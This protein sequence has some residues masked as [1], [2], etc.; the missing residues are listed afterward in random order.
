MRFSFPQRLRPLFLL[1]LLL[2]LSAAHPL[3]AQTPAW[4]DATSPGAGA[5]KSTAVDAAGNT[6]VTGSFIGTATFGAITLT[7]AGSFDIFVAKRNPAGVWQWATRAGGSS[8]DSGNGVAVDGSGNVVVTGEFNSPT[9][10]FGATT[11]TNATGSGDLFVAK[12]TPTGAWQWATGAGSSDDASGSSVA[13]DGSDNVVVTGFFRSPTITFGTITLTNAAAL[14]YDIF[15]AKLTP[16][17]AWQWATS[18]GSSDDDSG[19][20]VAV[21]GSGNVVVTGFFA[22][23]TL[24]FGATTLTSAGGYSDIFLARLLPDGDLLGGTVYLDTNGD[25]TRTAGEGLAPLPVMVEGQPGPFYLTTTAGAFGVGVPPGTYTLSLPNPPGY[26]TVTP[27]T[28]SAAFTAASQV[29]TTN[30]FGLHPTGSFN[31]LRVT[32]TAN[33][34]LRAGRSSRYVVTCY[35]PGTTVQSGV[36]ASLTLDP[37][38]TYT[39]SVPA[40]TTV[41]GQVV[42]WNVGTLAPFQSR[43]FEVTGVLPTTIPRGDSVTS[44]A[45]LTSAL[46]EVTPADNTDAIT[47]LIVGSY[48]PNDKQVSATRLTPAQVQAGPWLTYTIRFQNTGNDTAFAVLLRDTLSAHVQRGTLEVLAASH[49]M[50][51][52]L[53]GAGVADFR[54]DHILLPDSGRNEVASHGFV[55]YRVRVLPTL[56]LGDEVR[57]AAD[58]YFDFNAPVRTNTAVTQVRMP[59]GTGAATPRLLA[60][61]YP[62]PATHTVRVTLEIPTANVLQFRVLN[63]LGQVVWQE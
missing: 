33:S 55:Q 17:G 5:G 44:V 61:L 42:T 31:D 43:S 6:Y 63:A 20:S 53:K 36:T 12:L 23:P 50:T 16:T 41:S 47:S 46:A 62:N 32:L 2:L 3:C 45:T 4:L 8:D 11:L 37:Q 29:D 18:A 40:A 58:I 21:D 54:F 48:D 57:N 34:L 25:G 38:I 19:S 35:N 28:H 10:S 30:H 60:S 39:A 52:Q 51:W 15:V 1:A 9:I 59:L 13:V 24:T 14:E 49:P 56:A 22:S 27:A 7:S 26:H